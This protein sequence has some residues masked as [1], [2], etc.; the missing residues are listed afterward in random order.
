MKIVWKSIV[1]FFIVLILFG[2]GCSYY[3]KDESKGDNITI[4][5]KI[6]SLDQNTQVAENE[7]YTQ[8]FNKLSKD[9]EKLKVIPTS[10]N[11]IIIDLKGI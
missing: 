5:K 4:V 6:A 10:L 11:D 7:K 2:V 8:M 3:F 9:T 1:I